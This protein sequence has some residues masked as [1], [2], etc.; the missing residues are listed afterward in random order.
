[1]E[2]EVKYFP[3]QIKQSPDE[4]TDEKGVFEGYGNI[5][6]NID[7][8]RDLVDPGAFKKT[9]QEKKNRALFFMHNAHDLN[10]LIGNADDLKEDTNGLFVKGVIDLT[11]ETG[12]KAWKF[13]QEGIIDRMSI[14]YQ[15]IKKEFEKINGV[16]VRR[17]KEVKLYELSVIPVGMAMNPKALITAIKSNDDIFRYIIDNKDDLEMRDK[18]FSL[19]G[20]EPELLTRLV[21]PGKSTQQSVEPKHFYTYLLE[22]YQSSE[23]GLK[24]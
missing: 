8:G 10:N 18:I 12:R 1:M 6:H 21:E 23:G 4:S 3:C 2:C 24:Q 17:I 5:F 14:G 22:Q 9:I 11:F 16:E 15:T 20:I 13:I 7:E 19:Y